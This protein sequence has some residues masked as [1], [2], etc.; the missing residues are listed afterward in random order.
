MFGINL[1]GKKP[2][3]T[4]KNKSDGQTLYGID[5]KDG[6]GETAWF[7]K[8]GSLDS[9]TKTPRDDDED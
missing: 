7:T 8:D 5:Y 9:I 3:R 1:G 6:S 2:D 4:E